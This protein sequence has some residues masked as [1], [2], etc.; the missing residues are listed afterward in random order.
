M[1]LKDRRLQ[2]AFTSTAMDDEGGEVPLV[3]ENHGFGAPQD[4]QILSFCELFLI[5]FRD[6]HL[7]D[8]ER[9]L[10]PDDPAFF[11]RGQTHRT[12]S[13][14]DTLLVGFKNMGTAAFSMLI[15]VIQFI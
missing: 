7:V 3:V 14:L 10:D 1:F 8:K 13:R 5:G 9:V 4:L 2:V 11:G 6:F 15:P 12:E